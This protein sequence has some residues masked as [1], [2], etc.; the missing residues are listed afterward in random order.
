MLPQTPRLTVDAI[1][2]LKNRIV[3][4]KRKNPPYKGNFALPGSFVSRGEST[5]KAVEGNLLNK[6]CSL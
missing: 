5:E 4:V 1:I 3:L 2:L 6:I